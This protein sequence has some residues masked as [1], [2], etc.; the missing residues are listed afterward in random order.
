MSEMEAMTADRLF[1]VLSHPVRRKIILC[2]GDANRVS[3][4]EIMKAIGYS[5]SPGL[6]YHLRIL[7]PFLLKEEVLY[8]L[9]EPGN[10]VHRIIQSVQALEDKL[11]HMGMLITVEE[12]ERWHRDHD[13]KLSAEEHAKLMDTIGISEED[14]RNW[15]TNHPELPIK[16]SPGKRLNP[17]AVGGGF[18]DFC[19]RKGWVK[20]EGKEHSA[21]YYVTEWGIIELKRFGIEI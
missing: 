8:R 19:V 2:I 15:H 20:R 11:I 5:D 7:A 6:S 21:V 16:D 9:S 13:G 4:S 14:D 1:E 18:L 10:Q 12:H 3:F 17:F